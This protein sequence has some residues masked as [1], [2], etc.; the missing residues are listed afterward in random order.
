MTHSQEIDNAT[1]AQGCVY[2]KYRTKEGFKEDVALP[3]VVL[4]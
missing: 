3:L 2:R 4:G 1:G